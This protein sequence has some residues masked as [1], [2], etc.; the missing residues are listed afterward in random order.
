MCLCP[1][2]VIINEKINNLKCHAVDISSFMNVSYVIGHPEQFLT[3][4]SIKLFNTPMFQNKDIYVVVD[5]AHCVIKWGHDLGPIHKEVGGTI[6]QSH[7][8]HCS[9]YNAEG[10]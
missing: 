7:S 2:D 3:K 5:E 4:E 8:S 6:P 10:V 9:T 1:L